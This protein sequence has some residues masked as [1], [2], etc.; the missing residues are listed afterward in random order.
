MPTAQA[1]FGWKKDKYDPDP[2]VLHKR[3]MKAVRDEVDLFEWLPKEV[4][5]QLA[6]DC[7]GMTFSNYL[8]WLAIKYN[9][10]DKSGRFSPTWIYNGAR[11]KEGSLPYDDGCYPD[12]AADWLVEKGGLPLAFWPYI[13]FEK[14]TPPSSLEPEAAKWPVLKKVRIAGG[15]DG[16]LDVMSNLGLPVA[17]GTPWYDEWLN[18]GSDG[19]LPAPDNSFSIAGGHETLLY[20]YSKLINMAKGRNSWSK[21]YGDA[22]DYW[23]PFSSF[24]QFK[25]DG[26]YDAHYITVEWVDTPPEPPEPPQPPEPDPG[27]SCWKASA[28]KRMTEVLSGGRYTITRKEVT[29]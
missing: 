26:G 13:G 14:R 4:W 8:A 16:I 2:K 11:Y 9:L 1:R 3:T 18:P 10:F 17:I 24:T 28:Y 5:D 20:R 21:K 7:V 25:V 22:G 15:I 27:N 29:K 6:G 19:K 12:D 23:M